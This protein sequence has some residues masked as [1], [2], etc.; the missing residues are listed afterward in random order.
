MIDKKE[1]FLVNNYDGHNKF[2]DMYMNNN[3]ANFTVHWGKI[4]TVGQSTDYPIE[5]WYKKLKEK[6]NKGYEEVDESFGRYN[7]EDD[8]R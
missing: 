1:I 4:G 5:L 3:Q 7:R 2:Y 8:F 6:L